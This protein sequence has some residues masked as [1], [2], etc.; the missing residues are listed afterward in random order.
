M[1]LDEARELVGIRVASIRSETAST[2]QGV[3]G[4]PTNATRLLTKSSL[5]PK[6]SK[7]VP[8]RPRNIEFTVKSRLSESIRQSRV[9]S[10]S[11][12]FK[13]TRLDI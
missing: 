9:N 13:K 10:T 5:P 7:S 11:E 6:K 1:I 3:V 12:N 8:S 2:A 4:V